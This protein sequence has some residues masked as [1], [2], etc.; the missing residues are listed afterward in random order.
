MDK[1]KIREQLRGHLL[2]SQQ[3]LTEA[4]SLIGI[5]LQQKYA[6]CM[7]KREELTDL[8]ARAHDRAE[9]AEAALAQERQ[10]HAK[11]QVKLDYCEKAYVRLSLTAGELQAKL[12]RLVE[13]ASWAV[14]VADTWNYIHADPFIMHV[15]WTQH[16]SR[17][18]DDNQI[19]ACRYLLEALANIKGGE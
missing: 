4:K 2:Q 18:M 12:D 1:E 13:A 6:D 16:T 17:S 14:E 3:E 7:P 9:S 10:A 5:L 11:T 8:C 15:V 19:E